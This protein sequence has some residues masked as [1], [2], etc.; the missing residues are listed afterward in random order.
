MQAAAN[1]IRRLSS[2]YAIIVIGALVAIVTVLVLGLSL[3]R[4]VLLAFAFGGLV[5]LIPPLVMRDPRAYW[6]FLLVLSMP[7][8]VSKRTTTWLVQPFDLYREFGMPAT[9]T[10][11]LDFYLTDVILVA[12]L[13]PWLARLCLR[14][15]R[16]YF[17]KIGYTFVLYLAWA[18]II[19]LIGAKSFYLSIFEWCREVLYFVAFIYIINNIITRSQLRAVIVGLFVGLAIASGTVISFF[20]IGI[21]TEATAL[22]G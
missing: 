4:P 12:M 11:S 2:G 20:D 18:L 14:Q 8:D 21:G 3:L 19:S 9:G 17:P 13:L 10:L 1:I 7:F 6:L 16:I 22:S 15:D 5:L